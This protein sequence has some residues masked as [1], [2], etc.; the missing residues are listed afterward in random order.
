MLVM[1]PFGIG[2]IGLVLNS[3]ANSKSA[4]QGLCNPLIG[5]GTS[6]RDKML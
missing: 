2:G 5:N 4:G 1:N 6:V 3:N